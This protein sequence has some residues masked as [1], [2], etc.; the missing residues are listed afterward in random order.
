M[1]ITDLSIQQRNPDRVNV[2]IDGQYRFSLDVL[3]VTDLGIKAGQEIDEERLIQL[4]QESVFG[5]LY[6]RAFEYAMIR[7]RSTKEM[8]DYLWRKTRAGKYKTRTGEI[9]EREGVSKDV[10]DRVYDRLVSKGYISDVKFATHWAQNRHLSKGISRR[11]LIGELRS[12]G[13]EQGIIDEVLPSSAR[14]D[15]SEIDKIIAKKRARYDDEKLMQYL[16]RQGFPYDLVKSKL[17]VT[18]ESLFLGSERD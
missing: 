16:L 6:I 10:A 5:K 15:D 3:Q 17:S 9:K 13:V 7:P 4:E 14:H 1:K 8:R 12:K 2:A 18:A 11:K